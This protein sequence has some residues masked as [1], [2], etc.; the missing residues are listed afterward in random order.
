MS[1]PS[2]L[3]KSQMRNSH[4]MLDA[5]NAQRKTSTATKP[6]RAQHVVLARKASSS[7][8]MQE[9]SVAGQHH[10]RKCPPLQ[11]PRYH[12][13]LHM[14]RDQSAVPLLPPP[15][16]L[17]D[18]CGDSHA[19]AIHGAMYIVARPQALT[20]APQ[21]PAPQPPALQPPSPQAPTKGNRS[22]SHMHQIHS[23]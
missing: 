1:A 7:A 22:E 5:P 9:K 17:N 2:P 20:P 18:K 4:L 13:K 6:R 16:L 12:L 14:C 19:H 3:K 23:Y 15:P 21:P 11:E 8:H 10:D